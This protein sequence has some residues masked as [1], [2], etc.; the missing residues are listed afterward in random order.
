MLQRKRNLLSAALM[1]AIAMVAIQAHAQDSTA[2]TT[3]DTEEAT[4]LD[5]V[6]VTGIRSAIEKSIDTK[7]TSTSIVESVSAE[8][9][10]KLPDSSIAES[11]ARLPGLTA[12]RERGRATQINIRGFNGDFSTATLNGRE[13]ASTSDNRGVEFDQYPSE[14]LSQV[15]VYKTP[16]AALVGQGLSGTVDLQTVR[17]LSYGERTFSV[18]ARY[19]QN[20]NRDLKEKGYRFSATYIDQFA[21][22][23]LG[24]MLAVSKMDSPQ[25]GFQNETWGYTDL[26]GN[27]GVQVLGGGKLY[28]FDN[29]HER[30]GV[31]ATLQFKPND[32]YEGTLDWFHSKFEKT[33][34]KTG[35]EFGTIWG[36]SSVVLEDF[37]L[38]GPTAVTT[39][40][41]GVHPVIRMDSNPIDDTLDSIGFN[42]KFRIGDNWLINADVSKSDV[43]RKFRVLET[44]AGVSTNGGATT[45]DVSLDPSGQFYNYVLGATFDDPTTLVL[46]DAGGWGQDGYL[47]DF[48]IEDKVKAFR[49]NA[50]RSFDG[51]LFS[52][53]DFGANYSKRTKEKSSLE[54][55]LCLTDCTG[56]MY[57]VTAP[58]PGGI[59]N[60]GFG[61]IGQFGVYDANAAL[62]S[63]IYNLIGNFHTDIAAKNWEIS[64]ELKTLYF[65]AGINTDLGDMP[66]RGNIGFQKIYIDQSAEG[67]ST[68]SGNPGGTP[69]SDGIDYSVFLPSLNLS[70]E[71]LPETIVR[72]GLARQMARPR[73]DDLKAGMDVGINNENE[74]SAGGGNPRLKPWLADSVDVA[75]EKY[76]TTEAGNRGY[77]GVAWFHKDLKSYIYRQ[78]VEFD[79]AGFPLP[80]P[81]PGQQNYPTSTIGTI[82]QP[83]NGEGGSIRGLEL[84]ASVPLDLLW[85]P[86]AG[87]GIIATYSDTSSSI[88]PNGPGT[89]EP[90]SGLSKYVSNTTLYYE[91][92]GFSIRYSR[93]TR[94][95]FRGETR[96]Y[97][98]D[99]Q[100]INI[101]G[102]TVQ[103]AQMNYS[104]NEGMLKGLS[105]YLQV[106]NIGDEP[107]LT[108]N[109]GDPANRPV[110]YF[111]YGRTTLLGFS[112]KF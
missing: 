108:Y 46:T 66:L 81:T 44:Y 10:G 85:K 34:I 31:A 59:Q 102:E 37:E 88:H 12:Q 32:V 39:S 17:P 52:D 87:L 73:M 109:D 84:T 97:G 96:G 43:E 15:V 3:E 71:F 56:G 60:F 2:A 105:L 28:R 22:D 110:S 74:W 79:F 101:E 16:D 80:P 1:S 82:N 30:T 38:S 89:N 112:Y 45:L 65:K 72:L 104:F 75:L 26:P 50:I 94:S 5:R 106:S 99:Y 6:K 92:G 111:E 47:K 7:Q 40:W 41:S 21:D 36:P 51:G 4:E 48:T 49:L 103:D 13:Q 14:L 8:D 77:V 42:N 69:V 70:L 98:A 55:K 64:E 53:I 67:L 100:I 86:L 33:E 95:D 68:F 63:G 19:D 93:R 25:P 57:G 29:N 24:L 23:T 61:G 90:L 9:I 91:R 78:N 58:F 18:N 35:M 83:A 107:F 54:A 62:N 11:I 27:P 20:K 76:F